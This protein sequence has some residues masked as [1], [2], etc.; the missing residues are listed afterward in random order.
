MSSKLGYDDISD[1]KSIQLNRRINRIDTTTS[2]LDDRCQDLQTDIDDLDDRIGLL[3]VKI[4]E[5]TKVNLPEQI[6]S[7]NS[8][9]TIPKHHVLYKFTTISHL[10]QL[11]YNAYREAYMP[12][13]RDG[14]SVPTASELFNTTQQYRKDQATA[15]I[16]VAKY[17]LNNI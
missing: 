16:A 9:I 13:L 6:T 4:K 8:D 2:Q 10:A 5:L 15:W 1:K 14:C 3:E 12:T 7:T 17:L 11:L